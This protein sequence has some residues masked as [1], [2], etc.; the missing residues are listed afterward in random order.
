MLFDIR[1]KSLFAKLLAQENIKVVE[2]EKLNTAAFDTENRVL[3][4]PVLKDLTQDECKLLISHEVAHALY[5]PNDVWMNGIKSVNENLQKSMKHIMNVIEDVRIERKIMTKYP[6]LVTHYREGYKNLYEVRKF[7]SDKDV[8]TFKFIDRMNVHLKMNVS[9]K[10]KLDVKFAD[11]EQ[12]II[13]RAIACKTLEEIIVLAREL[14]PEH[15][16]EEPVISPSMIQEFMDKIFDFL[17][18]DTV[19]EGDFKLLESDTPVKIIK[20]KKLNNNENRNFFE[21]PK[22]RISDVVKESHDKNVSSQISEEVKYI[23]SVFNRKKSAERIRA[24]KRI[25]IGLLDMTNISS[26][27]LTNRVFSQET[28][29]N[30]QKNH[31]LVLLIDGSGSMSNIIED[32]VK[33][34][35]NLRDFCRLEKIPVEMYVFN[36]HSA[37]KHISTGFKLKRI[38]DNSKNSPVPQSL[39]S[40]STPLCDSLLGMFPIIEKFQQN[41]RP[42]KMSFI[43]MTDGGCDSSGVN[44]TSYYNP[45]S[46]TYAVPEENPHGSKDSSAALFKLMQD[47]FDIDI[48]TINLYSGEMKVTD[49][50]YGVTRHIDMPISQLK[51]TNSVD[52]RIFIN[53]YIELIA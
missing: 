30:K 24:Q 14:L 50:K 19:Q 44:Y 28:I 29:R 43:V 31:G 40:G 3:Y 7:F 33:Q 12:I 10:Y 15:G 35:E 52:S 34:C 41:H 51:V 46:K 9:G 21:I 39:I 47:Q 23:R 13:D 32:V 16:H 5:T 37:N 18:D 1:A 6:A 22:M 48:L 20:S 36:S 26:Y 45:K 2:S 8:N 25:D 42:D 4:L 53:K 27:K 17:N 38:M 49:K 11:Q